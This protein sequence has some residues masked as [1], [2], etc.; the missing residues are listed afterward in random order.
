MISSHD[1]V[2]LDDKA[3]GILLVELNLETL[4]SSKRS[5]SLSGAHGMKRTLKGY[6]TLLGGRDGKSERFCQLLRST[7]PSGGEG[8]AVG[9]AGPHPITAR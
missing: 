5:L 2:T 3:E 7:L 1:Y 4:N 9:M 6:W 8:H